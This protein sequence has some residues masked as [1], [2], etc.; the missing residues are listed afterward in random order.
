VE[1]NIGEFV[2]VSF[3]VMAMRFSVELIR[4]GPSHMTVGGIFSFSPG[5]WGWEE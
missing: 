1:R 4:D 5:I 2:V 3:W